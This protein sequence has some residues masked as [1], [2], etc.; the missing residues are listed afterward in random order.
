MQL[1][2]LIILLPPLIRISASFRPLHITPPL[3]IL[4]LWPSL[5]HSTGKTIL[6]PIFSV[7]NFFRRHLVVVVG[8]SFLHLHA[9]CL[10]VPLYVFSLSIA[11]PF[12]HPR[13]DFYFLRQSVVVCFHSSTSILSSWYFCSFL[14][15]YDHSVTSKGSP[16]Y[17]CKMRCSNLMVMLLWWWF[18]H[19]STPILNFLLTSNGHLSFPLLWFLLRRN[20]YHLR[21]IPNAPPWPLPRCGYRASLVPSV[22]SRRDDTSAIE[23]RINHSFIHLSDRRIS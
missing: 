13:S 11:S 15:F 14:M 6:S 16:R 10:C 9:F 3:S 7:F 12:F 18:S 17:V 20:S 8:I 19:Y 22:V 1:P 21:F 4:F 23:R 2:L 5:F